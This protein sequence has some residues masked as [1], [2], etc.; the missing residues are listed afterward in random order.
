MQDLGLTF[1]SRN[2]EALVFVKFVSKS[3]DIVDETKADLECLAPLLLIS[4]DLVN[5]KIDNVRTVSEKEA[6]V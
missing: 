2:T 3:V 1:L 4:V 6:F 5:A